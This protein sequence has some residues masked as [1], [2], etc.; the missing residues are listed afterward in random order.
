MR[1]YEKISA[2][3]PLHWRG[4]DEVDGVGMFVGGS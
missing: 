4:V 2:L 1:L 3:N